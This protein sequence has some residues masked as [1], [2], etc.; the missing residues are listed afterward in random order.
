MKRYFSVICMILPMLYSVHSNAQF[1]FVGVTGDY[2]TKIKEPGF[3]AIAF[4]TVNQ[5]IDI[6]PNFTW[7]LPHKENISGREKKTTWWSANLC[8]H[9]NIL[10]A[11]MLEG[12]GLMGLNVSGITKETRETVQGQDFKDKKTYYK[13]GLNVGIG[14]N[15]HLSD[16]FT[17]FA[18]VKVTLTDNEYFQAGFRLGILVRIAPDK[19]REP[20]E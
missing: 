8:G 19:E 3:S 12:Y 15:V 2:G 16:F 20:E 4:Y 1:T 9:Y 10:Q 17:P 18:E 13:P 11:G 7:Y 6:T 14:G 5:Q